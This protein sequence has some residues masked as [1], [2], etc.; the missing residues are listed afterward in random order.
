MRGDLA[1]QARLSLRPRGVLGLVVVV[2]GLTGIAAVY[3]PWFRIRFDVAML[4]DRKV[5][6]IASLAGWEAQPWV[7]A[8]AALNVAVVALGIAAAIDRRA[9]RTDLWLV[10][11]AFVQAALTG[12]SALLPPPATRLLGEEHL[13]R[14]QS[15]P[16][17]VP[18]DVAVRFSVDA[19]VG[20]WVSLASAALLLA[21]ALALREAR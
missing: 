16:A 11:V 21:A 9:S 20:L 8:I 7:W 6:T 5:G 14:L 18:D 17:V 3:L 2:A 4:G 1:L 13:T 15:L 12:L 19:T 10:A